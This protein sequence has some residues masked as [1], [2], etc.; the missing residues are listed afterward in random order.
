MRVQVGTNI[1]SEVFKFR[2]IQY[3]CN[4]MATFNNVMK[5]SINR[6]LTLFMALLVLLSSTGFGILEHQCLMKGKSIQFISHQKDGS[7]KIEKAS[8]CCSKSKVLS[9]T[10]T[11][12]K[13]TTCCKDLQK[14]ENLDT[15]ASFTHVAS[16]ALKYV[17]D[18]LP[19]LARSTVF[20]QS[21]WN[22]P[23]A[24]A[25]F[26][27]NSFS[28]RLHGRGMLHFIQTWRI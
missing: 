20:I 14:F 28:S 25:H 24:S 26:G 7:C 9:P 23:D 11:Y 5:K 17:S 4:V 21:E 1:N 6:L 2:I 10:G 12:F 16:K 27:S 22:A 3:F 18:G 13:K 19:W 8:S 15:A